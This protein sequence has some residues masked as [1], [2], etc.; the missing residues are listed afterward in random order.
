MAKLIIILEIL[1]S[2]P[3]LL[4]FIL[5]LVIA[6]PQTASIL[7]AFINGFLIIW[8]A[9]VISLPFVSKHLDK[10]K[11]PKPANLIRIIEIPLLI[12]TYLTGAF[13]FFSVF[14]I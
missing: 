6:V 11:R 10:T 9:T 12:L 1:A 4:V 3:V 14:G 7:D 5:I 13:L 2:I 8:I